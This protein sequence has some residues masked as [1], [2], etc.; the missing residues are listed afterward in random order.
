L[1]PGKTFGEELPTDV[2]L[3]LGPTPV[4]SSAGQTASLFQGAELPLHEKELLAVLKA[5]ESMQIDE[6]VERSENEVS[7]SEI[8]AALFELELAGKGKQEEFCE[9]VLGWRLEA[10]LISLRNEWPTRSNRCFDVSWECTSPRT[11]CSEILPP[12]L[13]MPV[14]R[15]DFV[16]AT[17]EDSVRP[18]QVKRT[19]RS[20]YAR[21]MDW[22]RAR[23]EEAMDDPRPGV[24][25]EVV[26]VE[27]RA[28]IDRIAAAKAVGEADGC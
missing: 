24:P 27:T 10:V 4:E 6:I 21:L 2:R 28:V 20:G 11:Q 7:P 22:F 19:D 16:R 13:D 3:Q 9:D 15:V 12:K 23:V 18:G 1:R 8:F 5:D 26:L 14:L 17:Q 25:Q